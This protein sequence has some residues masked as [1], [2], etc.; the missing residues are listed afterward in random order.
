MTTDNPTILGAIRET[1]AIFCVQKDAVKKVCTEQDLIQS[2][3]NGFGDE[4]GVTTNHITSMFDV[5]ANFEE[6]SAE[7]KEVMNRIMCCLLYTSRCV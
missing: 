7:Y 2:N 1:D 6:D 3:K 4:I 5:L